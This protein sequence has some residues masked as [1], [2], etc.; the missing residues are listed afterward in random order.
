MSTSPTIITMHHNGNFW[1]PRQV[2]KN[3]NLRFLSGD[4]L[5]LF[6]H[7]SY[8]FYKSRNPVEY[9]DWEI[10]ARIGVRKDVVPSVRDE[11]RTAKLVG[12]RPVGKRWEYFPAE[13][14]KI[15][16]NTVDAPSNPIVSGS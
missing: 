9:N 5:R 11:L 10:T 7:L 4:A 13:L 3:D 8:R 15:V 6:L 1:L 12:I 16:N 2:V 14:G